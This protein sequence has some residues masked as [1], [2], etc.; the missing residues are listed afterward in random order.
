MKPPSP[1]LLHA[2]LGKTIA[3]SIFVGALG[4]FLFVSAFPPSFRGWG[5][6]SENRIAGWA[7][8]HDAPYSRVEIQLFV[9]GNLV[10]SGVANEQRPDVRIAGWAL[11]DWHGY[12]FKLPS[13]AA[14][15]HVAKVFALHHPNRA[16]RKTL[17]MVGDAISFHVDESG[18]IYAVHE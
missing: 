2:L 5:E 15:P 14:G 18:G 4:L 9:D 10:A 12:S 11:D 8:N 3:E 1:K 16:N 6:L 17:Q 7:V 13:L